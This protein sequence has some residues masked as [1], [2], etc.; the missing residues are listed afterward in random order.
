LEGAREEKGEELESECEPAR[1]RFFLIGILDRGD[2]W[3]DRSM[4]EM[5][6]EFALREVALREM[7]STMGLAYAP[8]VSLRDFLWPPGSDRS[9]GLRRRGLLEKGGGRNGGGRTGEYSSLDWLRAW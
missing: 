6:E 3:R 5:G 7:A 2:S 4:G 8:V 1:G 9:S